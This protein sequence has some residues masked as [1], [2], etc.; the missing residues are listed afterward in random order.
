PW[1]D[2]IS[3]RYEQKAFREGRGAHYLTF[4]KPHA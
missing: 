1:Q 2:W 3:T 4:Q